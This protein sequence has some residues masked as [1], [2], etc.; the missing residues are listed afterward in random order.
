LPH[1]VYTGWTR[2]F[3]CSNEANNGHRESSLYRCGSGTGQEAGEHAGFTWHGTLAVAFFICIAWV[4]IFRA[5]DTLSLIRDTVVAR[6]FRTV[7]RLLGAGMVASPLIAVVFTLAFRNTTNESPLVFFVE[8]VAV[9]IFAAYWLTKSW[10]LRRTRAEQLALERKLRPA[11]IAPAAGP[12]RV[13]QIE[14][15]AIP[16]RDWESVLAQEQEA[17]GPRR[18]T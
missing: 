15:D 11:S 17:A 4:C 5:S 14:P 16:L 9:W 2:Y 6:R 1:Y 8:A 10:E 12:G 18:S 13:V 7:Y 3:D